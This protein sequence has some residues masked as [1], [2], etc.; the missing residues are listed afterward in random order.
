MTTK[1]DITEEQ[2]RTVSITVTHVIEI[3][4]ERLGKT[5]RDELF[6]RYIETIFRKLLRIVWSVGN[7]RELERALREHKFDIDSEEIVHVKRKIG[8]L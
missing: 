5:A 3:L 6:L 7:L 1:I 4:N 2:A 8:L